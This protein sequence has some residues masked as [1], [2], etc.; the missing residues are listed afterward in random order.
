MTTTCDVN[1]SRIVGV[2]VVDETS[3]AS[4]PEIGHVDFFV[5]VRRVDFEIFLEE[6]PVQDP[7]P[8]VVAAPEK[9]RNLIYYSPI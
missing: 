8:V 6:V 3:V 1:D 2:E 7:L 9:M 5:L 4:V